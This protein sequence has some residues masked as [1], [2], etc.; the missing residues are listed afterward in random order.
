MRAVVIILLIFYFLYK[1][2]KK[3]VVINNY[4]YSNHPP[5]EKKEKVGKIKVEN[6]KKDKK[7]FDKGKLGDFV[8]YEEIK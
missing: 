2:F 7:G 6:I 8:D 3:N 1:I 5:V 4:N